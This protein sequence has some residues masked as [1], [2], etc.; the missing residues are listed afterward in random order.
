MDKRSRRFMEKPSQLRNQYSPFIRQ[1][2]LANPRRLQFPIAIIG[3]GSIGSWTALGLGKMGCYNVS[4]YDGDTVKPHN[5]GSQLFT[6]KDLNAY[7]SFA[8]R[9]TLKKL[10]PNENMIKGGCYTD[11]WN[12]KEAPLYAYE[13]VIS[14]VDSI[15]TRKAIYEHII[16]KKKWFIDGRMGG[17]II[18]I[19]A[20]RTDDIKACAA[21]ERT[22][23]KK[24]AHIPC[25]QKSVVYNA[26]VCGGIITD[27]VAHIANKKDVP[28]ITEIDLFNFNMFPDFK[29]EI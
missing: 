27:M 11:M 13:I 1:L 23:W 21:Y 20:F 4:L 9:E 8:L 16:G 5:L 2:G 14:A 24:V 29:E 7:K 3:C 26:M 17:N 19:Y 25:S 6:E 18:T 28:Y 10:L 15:P 22:F 12:T